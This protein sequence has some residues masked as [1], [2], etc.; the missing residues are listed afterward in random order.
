[1]QVPNWF[2]YLFNLFV[3]AGENLVMADDV[4]TPLN[5]PVALVEKEKLKDA[6]LDEA[7]LDETLFDINVSQR[8]RE[9]EPSRK[10]VRI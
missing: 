7:P 9:E 3:D 8:S 1:M 2:G 6:P 10:V 4:V 5:P